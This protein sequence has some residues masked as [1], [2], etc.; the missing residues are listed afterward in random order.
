MNVENNPLVQDEATLVQSKGKPWKELSIGGTF[1]LLLA[2]GGIYAS[3]IGK[4]ADEDAL[5]AG[6]Q[7]SDSVRVGNGNEESKVELG[8]YPIVNVYANFFLKHARFFVMMSH[9]NHSGDGGNAF[10]VP[11]YPINQR[12]FRFGISWN[13]FN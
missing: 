9:V 8:N 6:A 2:G 13:F 3:G 10:L 7:A 11:H 1:G 12:V 5:L 4:G